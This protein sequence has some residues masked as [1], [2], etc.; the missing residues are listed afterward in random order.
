MGKGHLSCWPTRIMDFRCAPIRE[1]NA[2]DRHMPRCVHFQRIILS[3]VTR[4][5]YYLRHRATII[6]IIPQHYQPLSWKADLKITLSMPLYNP[7]LLRLLHTLNAKHIQPF[8]DVDYFDV[9]VWEMGFHGRCQLCKRHPTI[10]APGNQ[11]LSNS[12]LVWVAYPTN[13]LRLIGM[14]NE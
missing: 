9:D 8:F 3:T 13:K 2:R 4:I 14:M 6:I 5:N 12:E 10:C 7:P 1:S 11:L